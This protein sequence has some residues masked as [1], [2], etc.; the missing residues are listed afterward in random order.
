MSGKQPEERKKLGKIKRKRDGPASVGGLSLLDSILGKV[1][2]QMRKV[3]KRAPGAA[4]DDEA[5]EVASHFQMV[6]PDKRIGAERLACRNCGC[7]EME[8][9]MR[10]GDRICKRCGVVQNA[11]N[12]ESHEEEHRT[13]A[14]D[15]KKQDKKRAEVQ[16]GRGGG[17]VGV[18]ALSQVHQL[19]SA[20]ADVGGLLTEADHKRI[21]HYQNKVRTLSDALGVSDNQAIQSDARSLCETLVEN[22]RIHDQECGR[23]NGC[24][25]SFKFRSHALVAAGVLRTAM[26]KNNVNRLFEELKSALKGDDVDAADAKKVGKCAQLVRDLLKGSPFECNEDDEL[27]AQL[28]PPV[29][30]AGGAAGSA[31]AV[32]G[33][34]LPLNASIA[35][36]PRLRAEMQLP[37]MLERRA[38]DNIEDWERH[39]MPSIMP[40][41][42][43]ALALLRADEELVKTR[44]RLGHETTGLPSLDVPVMAKAAGLSEGTLERHRKDRLLPS[45]SLAFVDVAGKFAL[46]PAMRR[47]MQRQL[48][49][50]LMCVDGPVRAAI[51]ELPAR[52]IAACAIV[53]G[54]ADAAAASD[55]P[56]D[57]AA[58]AALSVAAVAEKAEVSVVALEA[59]LPRLTL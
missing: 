36:L 50:W 12:V 17:G 54:A 1:D 35:L 52:L 56:T 46:T 27:A 58:T 41:T 11:R 21:T 30:A 48:D 28:M 4:E 14:D 19:A 23:P 55:G 22:Q 26:Q 10:Q 15:D 57:G 16:S 47:A 45:P 13:F 9:D 37:F 32:V 39:G 7:F 42:V 53:V 8:N 43:A 29:A 6:K 5:L 34:E 31:S 33:G 38:Q 2:N 44:Q 3:S 18:A 20:Q 49:T 40:Q 24:R 25:L 59:A 51:R